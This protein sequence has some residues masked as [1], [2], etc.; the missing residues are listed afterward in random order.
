MARKSRAE[1]QAETRAQLLKTARQ[2][3]F[4]DGYHPTSLEKV[5]DAAGYSKGAVYSNFRNKDELCT[6][7]LDEVR[8][9]RLGEVLEI[10][11]TSD[12]PSRT[13]A[14]RDWAQR[15]IGDPGWTTLEVEFAAHAR[16]NEQL[17]TELAGRLDG[18]LQMLTTATESADTAD[19]KMPAREAATILLALGV[20][21]G[22]L[23]S[24][25]PS[26][27]ITGLIDT[28]RL[29]SGQSV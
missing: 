11:G 1:T 17:R 10:F 13:E 5:A 20:G 23:R 28:L 8:A 22:L 4:E 29:L 3:F 24:I 15:V 27:P 25:D 18:I 16:P 21:L 6:A 14:I 26:I 2:L 9:E 7:V 12:T 19:L